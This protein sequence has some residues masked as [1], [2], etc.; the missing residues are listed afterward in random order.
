MT[1][2]LLNFC[3]LVILGHMAMGVPLKQIQLK[4]EEMQKDLENLNKS[5][6]HHGLMLNTPQTEDIKECCTGHA[7]LCFGE[8]LDALDSQKSTKKLLGRSLQ[9]RIIRESVNDCSEDDTKSANCPA[10]DSYPLRDSRT[11]VQALKTLL[12]QCTA[13]VGYRR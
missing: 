6:Q 4:L 13:K 1:M 2:Q 8:K 12:Q 9:K 5:V 3:L 11:F 10:C 7:M